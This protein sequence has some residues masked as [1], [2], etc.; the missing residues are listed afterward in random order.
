[1][2]IDASV[3][4]IMLVDGDGEEKKDSSSPV[5]LAQQQQ[6]Q[7]QSHLPMSGMT[8]NPLLAFPPTSSSSSAAATTAT[9]AVTVMKQQQQQRFTLKGGEDSDVDD[10]DEDIGNGGGSPNNPMDLPMRI[11]IPEQPSSAP[12]IPLHM[13]GTSAGMVP[14]PIMSSTTTSSWSA[15]TAAASAIPTAATTTASTNSMMA[16]A[17]PSPLAS[18]TLD[19]D[20]ENEM[21]NGNSF[22]TW[23]YSSSDAGSVATSASTIHAMANVVDS[24]GGIAVGG[25]GVVGIGGTRDAVREGGGNQT[26]DEVEED[27]DTDGEDMDHHCDD[28]HMHGQRRRRANTIH[29]APSQATTTA[30]RTATINT[31]ATTS[32]PA[33]SVV[34]AGSSVEEEADAVMMQM[35][36]LP[37]SSYYDD[38]ADIFGEEHLPQLE[39]PQDPHQ[40]QQ[41][42]QHQQY[43]EDAQQPV[44][45]PSPASPPP[46]PT[47]VRSYSFPAVRNVHHQSSGSATY[48]TIMSGTLSSSG[49]LYSE[50]TMSPTSETDSPT[51]ENCWRSSTTSSSVGIG[52]SAANAVANVNSGGGGNVE[53]EGKMEPHIVMSDSNAVPRT[54]VH[55]HNYHSKTSKSRITT[56]TTTT[57]AAVPL[58]A[59][60]SSS[61]TA[62]IK[63][64]PPDK[65]QKRLE[66]NRE[67]ARVS[68]RRRKFYLEELECKVTKLSEEMDIGRMKHACNG[69]TSVRNARATVLNEVERCMPFYPTY[70]GV[71]NP[72]ASTIMMTTK[73]EEEQVDLSNNTHRKLP[74]LSSSG[75]HHNITVPAS[76]T[77]NSHVSHHPTTLHNVDTTPLFTPQLSRTNDELQIVQI[78]MKQQLTSLVQPTL[79]KFVLWLSLQNEEYYRGT[80]S[81]S[82]RLSAA[83]IGERVSCETNSQKGVVV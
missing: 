12:S 5:V 11:S 63:A 52:A 57:T 15:A 59:P 2:E 18:P 17:V 16:Y 37:P 56:T 22:P 60:I 62:A 6:Q 78:F 61:S 44:S 21:N 58:P 76:A 83:R 27:E 69:L 46:S 41:Q 51:G 9:T 20:P 26:L 73:E 80:R 23:P 28:E 65:R 55:F 45:I 8:P 7:Q 35:T 50:H 48:G 33:A 34:A 4:P 19:D 25:R 14:N 70:N 53:T 71:A 81:A 42:Q 77:P 72:L 67:S 10:D 54:Q 40:Q 36:Y 82:E 64:P 43:Q 39:T 13:M 29:G 79:T 1:V 66:R 32:L 49:S 68:R 3:V 30:T 38:Q 74:S 31:A 24:G 47:M 75:I